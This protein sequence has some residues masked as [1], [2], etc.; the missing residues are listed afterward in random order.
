[1]A[2]TN[3]EKARLLVPYGE[4]RTALG[5]IGRSTLHLLINDGQ[6]TRVHIGARSFIT[7]AS[8]DAY[9]ARLTAAAAAAPHRDGAA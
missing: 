7:R 8:I 5:G 1:M 2:Q 4:T 9:I 6:L 3:D